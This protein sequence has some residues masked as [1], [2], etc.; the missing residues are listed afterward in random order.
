MAP[1]SMQDS[2]PRSGKFWEAQNTQNLR[3]TWDIAIDG[4]ADWAQLV[5]WNDSAE[6]TNFQPSMSHGWS[7]LDL[8]AYYVTWFKTGQAPT[9]T[10]DAVYLTHRKQWF[11]DAPTYPQTLLSTN[12]GRTQTRDAV[13]ALVFLT[14]PATVT[15]KA[16]S[17][18]FSCSAPAGVS[19]CVAPLA[20]GSM[21]AQV[22]RSG[23]VKASVV[24]PWAVS[25]GPYVQD[26]QYVG[27]SSL[28]E[29]YTA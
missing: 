5:T 12:V 8:T 29:G 24:S 18:T 11:S 2:R 6:A 16:G 1:V 3:N 22:T 25:H 15:I 27:A 10:K 20:L 7:F 9:I 13:E 4:R 23:V 26:M 14:A 21:S 28:R 19:T 17:S